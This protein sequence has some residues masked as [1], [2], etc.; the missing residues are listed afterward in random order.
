MS[1]FGKSLL[2]LLDF[3][4][5]IADSFFDSKGRKDRNVKRGYKFFSEGYV[6]EIWTRT[7]E[8]KIHVKAKC[9]KSQK[10]NE[11]PHTLSMDLKK[12][13]PAIAITKA[14]CSC[15]AG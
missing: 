12:E 11:H 3:N 1:T 5:L 6:H 8:D 15:E 4:F 9:Y 10:K 13:V 7:L 2:D 14:H